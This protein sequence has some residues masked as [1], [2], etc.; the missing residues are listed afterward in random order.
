VQQGRRASARHGRHDSGSRG[1]RSATLY[2][3]L[4]RRFRGAVL[5]KSSTGNGWAYRYVSFFGTKPE[6]PEA[7][8]TFTRKSDTEYVIDGPTYPEN[9]KQVTEHH[10]CHKL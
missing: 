9:G 8:A 1:R 6:A 4:G 5:A 10:D 2:V 3:S 7:D